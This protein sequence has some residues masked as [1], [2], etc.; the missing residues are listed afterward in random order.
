MQPK[1][2]SKNK[3]K[4]TFVRHEFLDWLAQQGDKEFDQGSACLCVL[5]EYSGTVIIAHGFFELGIVRANTTYT[6]ESHLPAW[7][8]RVSTM[9]GSEH[10]RFKQDEIRAAALSS[11]RYQL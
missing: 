10:G 5:A 3:I 6:Q 11:W 4:T 8:Q 9:T 2:M 1:M 7:A